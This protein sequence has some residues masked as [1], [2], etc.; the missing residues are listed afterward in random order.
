M[1]ILK[2]T[3]PLLFAF[4]LTGCYE[5]FIPEID[6]KPVLCLNSLITAGHPIE[7]NVTHTWLFSDKNASENHKVDDATVYIY[8]NGIVQESDYLPQEGDRIKIVA[9]SATYGYAEAEVSVPVSVPISSLNWEAEVTRRW[10]SIHPELNSFIFSINLK[11][12]M[13]IK[14]DADHDN[15]YY[16]G[17]Y[18]F[19]F[20][21]VSP[22]DE[23]G[24]QSV[25]LYPGRLNYEAE[26]IFSEHMDALDEIISDV[27]YGFTFFTDS[28]FA[29]KTYTLNLKFED[30]HYSASFKDFSEELV[31]CGLNLT[32]YS[33]SESFYNWS[34]YKWN[35]MDG[36]IGDLTDVGF[37]DPI[38]GY[39]NVSTGAGVVAAQSYASYQINL[40]D[41]LKEEIINS[42]STNET[43][44]P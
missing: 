10:V 28:Q 9:E 37:C 13:G 26:P 5:D 35:D 31:D 40:K 32:L 19:P 11:A 22:Y 39:S 14:D 1:G 41:F 27:A 6:T 7:V 29:G 23:T 33:V 15:Y 25:S 21:Y 38:W 16:F 17:Y 42:L 30:I 8:A 12:K 3:Y 24:Y 43:I 18:G 4:I 34:I 36:K 44:N 2:K 20:D